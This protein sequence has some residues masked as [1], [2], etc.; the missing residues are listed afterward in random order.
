[1]ASVNEEGLW[2]IRLALTK[3]GHNPIHLYLKTTGSRLKTLTWT[4][5]QF[6]KPFFRLNVEMALDA[7]TSILRRNGI[8][9]GTSEEAQF[10]ASSIGNLANGVETFTIDVVRF[11]PTLVRRAAVVL[12]DDHA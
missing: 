1:M 6:V 7:Y 2:A 12:S 10:V 8:E 3:P 11:D 5:F 4:P 9:P